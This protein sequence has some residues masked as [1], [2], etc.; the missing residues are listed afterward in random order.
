VSH[1]R[2]MRRARKTE[3]SAAFCLISRK[4]GSDGR[5]QLDLNRPDPIR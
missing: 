4:G 5:Q 2:E 3:K 1:R